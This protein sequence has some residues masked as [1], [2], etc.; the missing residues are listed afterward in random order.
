MRFSIEQKVLESLINYVITKPYNEVAQIVAQAQ[1]DIKPI[2][3][4][5]PKEAEKETDVV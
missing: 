5:E 3:E 2:K 1:A 4:E